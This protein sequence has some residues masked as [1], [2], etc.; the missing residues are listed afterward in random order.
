MDDDITGDWE[1]LSEADA[2]NVG[3]SA[4]EHL[5]EDEDAF[6]DAISSDIP[7]ES[8]GSEIPRPQPM[9]I[10]A[11]S[12]SS[13]SNAPTSATTQ[14]NPNIASLSMQNG[15]HLAMEIRVRKAFEKGGAYGLFS[16]FVTGA[17]RQ[18]IRQWTS[19]K[20]QRSGKSVVPE[21]ELNAYLGLEIA[22]SI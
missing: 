21:R 3:Y 8:L 1:P 22:M 20:L 7:T 6:L 15:L 14:T 9:H 19:V 13:A 16:L 2:D 11:T 10:S 4:C 12:P 17:L 5:S 18:N